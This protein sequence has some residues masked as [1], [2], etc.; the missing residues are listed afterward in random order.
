ML[1]CSDNPNLSNQTMQCLFDKFLCLFG[2]VK[3]SS[4]YVSSKLLL[5]A[6]VWRY[7]LY[8]NNMTE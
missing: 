2:I 1:I 3:I 8:L 5:D 4:I 6:L 7:N